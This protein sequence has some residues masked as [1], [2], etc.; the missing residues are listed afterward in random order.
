MYRDSGVLQHGICPGHRADDVLPFRDFT[1]RESFIT[2]SELFS[3]LDP[4]NLY[5]PYVYDN[6]EWSH[7]DD[8]GY[9][10]G[11]QTDGTMPGVFELPKH[12]PRAASKH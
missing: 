4:E 12:G 3:F 8:E 9:H 1:S 10:F 6:F 7:C 5:L 11:I 2:N